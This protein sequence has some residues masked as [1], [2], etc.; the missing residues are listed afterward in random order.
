MRAETLPED[1]N[2]DPV[3]DDTVL[4]AALDTLLSVRERWGSPGW[5]REESQPGAGAFL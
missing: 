4:Y 2:P 3:L 5:P 1:S